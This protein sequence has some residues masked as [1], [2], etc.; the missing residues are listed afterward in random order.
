MQGLLEGKVALITGA[1]SGVGR[2]ACLLFAEHGAKVIA[3]DVNAD[4][5]SETAAM[6]RAQN[7]EAIAVECDVADP[8]S[9]DHAVAAAVEAF[10]RLD[11]LYNNA[12]ITISPVPGKGLRSLIECEG[13]DMRRVSEVNVMGVVHGCQ[14][15][16]RQFER[17]AKDGQGGGAIVST[18]SVAGLIGYGGVFYGATKG[19]VVQLTRALAIEVADKGIRVNAVC[20]AGMLTHYAGMDPDSEHRD[21][22]LEGMGRV[23]PLGRAIDPRDTASAALFLCSDLASNVTGVNLPVDGGL[24]AGRKVGG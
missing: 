15:A 4:N 21:R 2:A 24:S 20:P 1:G 14:S 7:G 17:Q 22:I 8:A 19:A 18:A 5:A 3:A 12:G 23:H 11:C 9:V 10:G 6:V 13:E 16:I